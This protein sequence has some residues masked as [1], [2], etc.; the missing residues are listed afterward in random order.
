MFNYM[1]K[2]DKLTPAER[3]EILDRINRIK[4]NIPKKEKELDKI[5][6]DLEKRTRTN[7]ARSFK[8]Q[9]K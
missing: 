1:L 5:K 8:D 3:K 2:N 6:K 9:N 7:Q 4:E